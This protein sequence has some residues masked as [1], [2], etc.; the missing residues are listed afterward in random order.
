MFKKNILAT[1][2]LPE[3]I[4]KNTSFY[5]TEIESGAFEVRIVLREDRNYLC[6][7]RDPIEVKIM[8]FSIGVD[9]LKAMRRTMNFRAQTSFEDGKV[10]FNVFEFVRMLGSL[11]G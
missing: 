11:L 8:G 2:D 5:F 4:K 10:T 3:T 7:P 9:K 1:L 6:L